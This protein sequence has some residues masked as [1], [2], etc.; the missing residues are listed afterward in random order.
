MS[1]PSLFET[2]GPSVFLCACVCSYVHACV[3]SGD[4]GVFVLIILDERFT[5]YMFLEKYNF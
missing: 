4:F 3:L 5:L 2:E 1:E